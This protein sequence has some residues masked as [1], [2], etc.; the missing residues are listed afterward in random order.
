MCDTTSECTTFD[1]KNKLMTSSYATLLS[2]AIILALFNPWMAQN[3]PM[4]I[5]WMNFFKCS[6]VAAVLLFILFFLIM[7]P[8]DKPQCVCQKIR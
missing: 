8:W 4:K 7:Q 1:I 2:L 3:T 6:T 5:H